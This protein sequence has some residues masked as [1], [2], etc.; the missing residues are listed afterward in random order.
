MD[1]THCPPQWDRLTYRCYSVFKDHRIPLSRD[2]CGQGRDKNTNLI[3][4]NSS[5]NTFLLPTY[6]FSARLPTDRHPKQKVRQNTQS[7]I[8]CQQENNMI[9]N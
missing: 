1:K 8:T 2:T 9:L 4:S 6:S 5:V 3:N 7:P